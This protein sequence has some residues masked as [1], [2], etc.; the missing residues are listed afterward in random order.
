MSPS[1]ILRTSL[2]F[3]CP[4]IAFIALV[5][6]WRGHQLPGGGFVGGLVMSCAVLLYG[7]AFDGKKARQ[8][9]YI[10][11]L[12]LVALGLGAAY[13][14]AL[15]APLNSDPFMKGEWTQQIPVLGELG[16]PQLFDLGVMLL[17]LGMVSQ[18]LIPLLPNGQELDDA[19]K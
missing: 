8:I 4:L 2:K 6:F 16:S 18:V 15:I 13:V 3:L 19:S 12:S 10:H 1:L 7:F 17:V 11:P 9:L 14:S 5:I